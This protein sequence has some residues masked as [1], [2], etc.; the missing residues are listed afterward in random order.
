MKAIIFRTLGVSV[1]VAIYASNSANAWSAKDK[2][3]CMANA[4]K[5]MPG[6]SIWYSEYYCDC[7]GREVSSGT[8][9]NQT[10]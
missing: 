10:V 2:V 4:G 3:E 1:L 9:F 7:A 5:A 8:A 6:A